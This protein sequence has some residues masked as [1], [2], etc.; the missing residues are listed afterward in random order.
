MAAVAITGFAVAVRRRWPAVPAAWLAYALLLL[1]VSGLAQ[2]GPSL[3]AER[4]SYLPMI[5]LFAA[6]AGGV[7]A[8]WR[9]KPG[10]ARAAALGVTATL[11][12]VSTAVLSWRQSTVWHDSV[13]LWKHTLQVHPDCLQ[14]HLNLGSALVERQRRTE[15]A[16]HYRECTRLRPE[17]G[18][19]WY[20]LGLQLLHL[21]KG[22]EALDALSRAHEL[23]GS[24]FWTSRPA[25]AELLYSLALAS[26][27]AGQADSALRRCREALAA[28]PA[29]PHAALLL[30]DLLAAR[31]ERQEAV[32]V[33][34]AALAHAPADARLR[35]KR[36]EL[37][38]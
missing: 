33:L 5:P 15:A 22:R 12:S 31:G 10:R 29:Y 17:Y 4:Y 3:V 1:P 2:A 27:R 26:H 9:R 37:R 6:L 18:N 36:D 8:F 23:A 35:Q 11:V 25:P 38:R 24:G 21:G 19:A 34:E 7:L 16:H 30:A 32:A 14:A 20:S 13:T 28:D